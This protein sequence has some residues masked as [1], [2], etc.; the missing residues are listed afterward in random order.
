MKILE[1]RFENLNSLYGEWLIDFTDPE[2]ISNG[3]FALTGP[4]GAGKST[5]L[6]AIC[7]A[8]Y[9]STP[10]L[11]KI[12]KSNNE[13]MSRQTGVCYAEV[14]FE[15]QAGIYR[16]HWSQH[17]SRKKAEGDLQTPKH[18]ISE[19]AGEKK[20]IESQLRKVAT[21]IE[22]K[23]GMDFDRF[24]RSILLAQG[25][26]DTF[27][28]A[29]VEEKS[30]ILE[31]ITGT[32]I[33][34]DISVRVHGRNK[35]ERDKLELIRAEISG[36][37]IL[38]DEEEKELHFE[39]KEKQKQEA[40][41]NKK[42]TD[43]SKAIAWLATIKN[44]Q[45]EISDFAEDFKKL[46]EEIE[47]FKPQRKILELA[48]KAAGLDAQ[49]ANLLSL[50]KQQGEDNKAFKVQISELPKLELAQ[51]QSKE[52]LVKAEKD[53]LNAKETL[54]VQT[55]VFQKVRLIDQ[56]V[57][58]FNKNL[59][60]SEKV[61]NADS[62]SLELDKKTLSK[63]LEGLKKVQEES[64]SIESYIETNEKDQWLVSGLAGIEEQFNSLNTISEAIRKKE[65]AGTDLLKTLSQINKKIAKDQVES[66]KLKKQL[67]KIQT[68]KETK[69]KDL[70]SLLNGKLLREFRT[71]KETLLREKLF[72]N[73]ISDLEN[74]RLQ[75]EDGE[76][77][78][79]CGAEE[80][81]FAKGNV[82]KADETDKKIKSLESLIT[83]AEKL[84]VEIKSL[85]DLEKQCLANVTASEKK[86][87]E[88]LAEKKG[89]EKSLTEN[90]EDKAELNKSF[91]DLRKSIFSK[92][93]PIGVKDSPDLDIKPL[94]ISL[95]QR[96]Q[97]WQ[98]NQKK[99]IE[100][101]KEVSKLSAD[102]K[103]AE[104]TIQEKTKSLNE[105]KETANKVSKELKDKTEER[106]KLFGKLIPDKEETKLNNLIEVAELAEKA[107]RQSN[108]KFSQDLN[109][110]QVS[111]KALNERI[112]KR[113]PEL[114]SS[115]S[116]FVVALK[117]SGFADEENF[118][119]AT[120]PAPEREEMIKQANSLETRQTVMQATQKDREKRLAVEHA[121]EITKSKLEDLE[122]VHKEL[123]ESLKGIQELISALK[124][125]LNENTKAKERIKDKQTVIEA[126]KNECTHWE[127]LHSLIGS[128]DGKKYRN[129]AQGL[130]FELMVSHANRQLEKMTDRYLLIRDSEEPLELNVVDNYQAGEIR[131]TKN[132]SGGESFIISLT[133]A[134]GLS[135]MASRK[136]RVDSLFLDEGFGTLDEDSLETALETLSGL[137]QDGKLIGIISHV[138]ALKERISTQIS[139]MQLA[140]GKSEITGPGCSKS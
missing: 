80:H 31:Q 112:S 33:Y 37:V 5:I 100:I 122:P 66:L 29:N 90:S 123:E 113:A 58:Q 14:L 98:E 72:L 62:E 59:A 82:P 115:E 43:S 40:E 63:H 57:N 78:P 71:E 117:E 83:K 77:C 108:E 36:I 89:I 35:A 48:L 131:S 47:L 132:L 67:E 68:D 54:K 125:K 11:G 3:I 111:I 106:E 41:I 107:Q 18:E 120:F 114:K 19:G 20:I 92:L 126:Q 2:Y 130:T 91:T 133:L 53:V 46:N 34:S 16:C 42:F 21:T 28:K 101:D 55:P 104:A 102:I 140:G 103:L 88:L 135:K 137:H 79:L 95:Q 39:L 93:V 50:R 85:E 119:A 69:E 86:A 116:S 45:K 4:T 75:L 94:R 26:F 134:L 12:T 127:K 60:D 74:H 56:Q 110:A 6:D 15:S 23:T 9:G 118:L 17:R 81:P 64:K 22:E 128:A 76:A 32:G 7:L 8:L 138:P 13:I 27:L 44:L 139:I 99:Y 105:K 97:K 38:E 24:T 49:F 10:R 73:K 129:F 124:H 109:S 84:E 51:K 52:L 30:K 65:A 96:L 25:G 1:L 61:F 70:L 121:K 87:A 136:V